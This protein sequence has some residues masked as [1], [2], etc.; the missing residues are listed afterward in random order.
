MRMTDWI[1]ESEKLPSKNISNSQILQ[2]PVNLENSIVGN[3]LG[4]VAFTKE[5]VLPDKN[6]GEDLHISLGRMDDMGR[7]FFNGE[8][9]WSE[10]R[11]S[12]SYADILFNIPAEKISQGK[13]RIEARVLN[14]LWGGGLTGPADKMYYSSVNKPDRISLAGEWSYRKVF[15]LAEVAPI[16]REGKPL[17][18]TSSALFNGMINPLLNMVIFNYNLISILVMIFFA[19]I[20]LPFYIKSGVFT[21]PEFLERRFDQR[22]KYY[23]SGISVFSGVFMDVSA[24]LYGSA[25]RSIPGIGRRIG[26]SGSAVAFVFTLD[27]T[28][29]AECKGG[30]DT[31]RKCLKRVWHSAG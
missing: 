3:Q 10:V 9:V 26:R 12:K 22:S 11:N 1:K 24:T 28:W 31:D 23:F 2:L 21:M 5:I 4:E 29:V 6:N 25:M 8:E 15:D 13:N 14:V 30:N 16:P 20:F 7:V 19:W 17:F 18:L 27:R